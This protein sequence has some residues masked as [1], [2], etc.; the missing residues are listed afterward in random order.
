[1]FRARNKKPQILEFRVNGGY[2]DAI[3]QEPAE[4]SLESL[5]YD[6]D[7]EVKG[8]RKSGICKGL[9]LSDDACDPIHFFRNEW[10]RN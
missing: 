2:Q 8:F 6:L 10:W 9:V 3:C 4:L 7:Y 1:L 5:D